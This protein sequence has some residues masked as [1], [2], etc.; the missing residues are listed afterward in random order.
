MFRYFENNY[1]HQEGEF[2][3]ET[4]NILAILPLG[5]PVRKIGKGKKKRKPFEQVVHQEM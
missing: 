3:M 5:K 2:K 1:T 4:F